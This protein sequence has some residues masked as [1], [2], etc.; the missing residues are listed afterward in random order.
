MEN[1]LQDIY[2]ILEKSGMEAAI[3]PGVDPNPTNTSVMEG[4]EIYKKPYEV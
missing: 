1:S 3:F 2:K 4:A